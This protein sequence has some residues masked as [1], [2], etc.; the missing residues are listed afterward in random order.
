MV[1]SKIQ[2]LTTKEKQ[3]TAQPQS[4]PAPSALS[5][6]QPAKK[7]YTEATIQIRLADGSTVKAQFKPQDP[8]RTVW[9]HVSLLTD[10]SNFALSTTFP[11]KVY[12][13]SA[14]DTTTLQQAG[15]SCYC[16]CLLKDLV[17]N[18]TVVVTKQ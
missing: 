13:G 7:E 1:I 15:L 2:Y 5:T 18:G 11:R 9:N 14:L 3:N 4:A 6:S 17:P 8:L 16:C 12:T 10:S